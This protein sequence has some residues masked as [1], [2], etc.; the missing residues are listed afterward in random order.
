MQQLIYKGFINER[1]KGE[2]YNATFIGEMDNPIAQEFEE[3]LQWKQVSV[4]Y[5]ISDTEKTKKELTENMILAMAGAVDADYTDRYS[6]ITGYLW[7]DS[8]LNVG[9]HDLLSELECSIGK[10]I[11]MEVDVHIPESKK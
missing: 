9:G 10:F 3:S 8:K 2:C 11:Y 7:T 5:W 6:D 4:R 1:G